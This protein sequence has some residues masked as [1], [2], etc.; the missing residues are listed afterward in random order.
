MRILP[1]LHVHCSA[2]LSIHQ[3]SVTAT[4][5]IEFAAGLTTAAAMNQLT[6]NLACEWA[7]DSIRVNAVAPWYIRTDLAEQVG[8]VLANLD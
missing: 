4:H 3:V 5:V 8:G 2:G 7:L 1:F 6:R